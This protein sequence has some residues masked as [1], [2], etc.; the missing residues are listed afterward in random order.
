MRSRGNLLVRRAAARWSGIGVL[1]ALVSGCVV[2]ELPLG[3]DRVR[4]VEPGPGLEEAPDLPDEAAPPGEVDR[5]I[6]QRVFELANDARQEEGIS[7]LE[8]H[9]GLEEVARRWSQYLARTG[10][11]LAHNPGFSD[12]VPDGWRAVGENVGW[13][14]DGGRMSPLEVAEQVHEGWMDSPGHRENLLQEDFTHLGVGVAH[15]P[16]HGYYLTQNFATY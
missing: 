3:E 14:D 9:E 1:S 11:D 2:V 6:E 7:A 8:R 13:I 12:Q 5:E 10:E 16:E 4:T 15:D